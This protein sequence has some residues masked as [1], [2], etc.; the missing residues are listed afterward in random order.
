MP[1]E[2]Y[3]IFSEPRAKHWLMSAVTFPSR[4]MAIEFAQG[5]Q[6]T[7]SGVSFIRIGKVTLDKKGW[8]TLRAKKRRRK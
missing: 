3:V 2:H 6:D 4:K 8:I 7:R 5:W 1:R